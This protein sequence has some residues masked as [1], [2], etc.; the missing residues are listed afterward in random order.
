MDG[1]ILAIEKSPDALVSCLKI[2]TQE[3][4]H[5]AIGIYC[6]AGKDRTGLISALVL[7]ILGASD[8]EII[9][10][11]VLSDKVYSQLKSR[12]VCTLIIAPYIK[13]P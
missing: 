9:A 6:T 5:K 4:E 12:F 2:I 7:S 3:T 1:R 8:E 10:D 11:Y 13:C